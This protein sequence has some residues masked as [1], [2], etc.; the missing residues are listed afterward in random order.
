MARTAEVVR[1]TK[2][3][4][5]RVW[6][7]LDGTGESTVSTGVGSDSILG[8]EGA[9]GIYAISGDDVV[10][11][12]PGDDYVD[13]GTGADTAAATTGAMTSVIIRKVGHNERAIVLMLYPMVANVVAMAVIL[14]FVYHPMPLF[15]FGALALMSVL[16]LIGSILIIAAYRTAPAII[17]APM[18]YSQIIWA[19][20]YG[21]LLFDE[22]LDLPT[23]IGTGV[24]IA[25]G[26]Y[27]V[28]RE[29]T[30]S[31]SENRPVLENRSR[32]DTGIIPRVGLWLRFFERRKSS[33]KSQ[34]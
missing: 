17:V 15:D 32:F 7:D 16:G 14:P 27:I 25:S 28:L 11:A 6:I 30:P 19:V 12:G 20:F 13:S 9:D 4:Q 2:E 1:E 8:G 34:P 5:I 22:R 33:A 21:W 29:G 26:I 10:F 24:I 23:A 31:V 18:Q 3:T